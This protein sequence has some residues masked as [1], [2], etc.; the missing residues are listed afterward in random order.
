MRQQSVTPQDWTDHMSMDESMFARYAEQLEK[1]DFED[2]MRG[3]SC[4][5]MQ[6]VQARQETIAKLRAS[7]QYL[8]S[9]WMR[10]RVTRTM[11]TST[12]ILG[13]GLTIAGGILTTLTAGAAAPVLIAGLATS[14]VG[15]ATNIGSSM[16][17]KILNSRQIKE[18]N[19]AFERDKDITLK[20]EA[21][22][23]DVRRYKDSAHLTILV[24]TM[25]NLLGPDH[26]L[27]VLLRG[28]LVYDL[29]STG[30]MSGGL[31]GQG[32]GLAAQAVESTASAAVAAAT[33]GLAAET[34]KES[35]AA[36]A[37]ETGNVVAVSTVKAEAALAGTL[38][39][40][41]GTGL[42]YSALDAGALVEGGKVIGQNSFKVAGQVIIGIS[43]AFLVWDAIDL[44]F[45]ISDLVRK[46]GS[47][48]ARVLREKAA[49]LEGALNETVGMYSIQL[50]D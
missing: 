7:A 40:K 5:V 32:A 17:E 8:D 13:G 2:E 12:S 21:Q 22:I 31:L 37:S 6:L 16:V 29:R 10:C 1:D 50:P 3:L 28:I 33:V 44:G 15:A 11:G 42:R 26:L 19:A 23:E 14:S 38:L 45:T 49:T 34:V 41:G 27:V 24:L 46:Q 4:S 35:A 30:G 47:K 43:A 20:L 25:Q 36:V 39:E 48:A 9:I 18:M